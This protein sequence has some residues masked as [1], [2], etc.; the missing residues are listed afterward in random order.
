MKK[1]PRLYDGRGGCTEVGMDIQREVKRFAKRLA[2]K[3]VGKVDSHDLRLVAIQ[4]INLDLCIQTA[5]ML[6]ESWV[7]K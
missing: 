3:Y 4:E 6:G 1:L 7:T 5:I 2:N